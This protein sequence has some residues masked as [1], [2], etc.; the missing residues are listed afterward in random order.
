MN[1]ELALGECRFV[2]TADGKRDVA[3]SEEYTADTV[4]KY[5]RGDHY[6]YCRKYFGE[7]ARLAD[8]GDVNVITHFDLVAKFNKD[9]KYFDETHPKYV[10][11][12]LVAI[13]RLCAAGKMFEINTD[14]GVVRP[15]ALLLSSVY[16][17]GGKVT[18]APDADLELAKGA[19]KECGFD[20]AYAIAD[21]KLV[22]TEL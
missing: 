21:G 2:P 11:P 20:L 15:S 4:E 8:R 19:A 13:E 10:M 6:A 5:F 22:Q 14:D 1:F 3:V 7:A 17:L 16:E 18:F 12:A 9:G